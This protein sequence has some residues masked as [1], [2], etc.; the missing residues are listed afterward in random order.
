MLEIKS[1][2]SK[3][4]LIFFVII[5]VFVGCVSVYNPATQK[6]EYYIIDEAAEVNLGKSLAKQITQEQKVWNNLS[7]KARLERIG[8]QIVKVSDRPEINY[9]FELIDQAGINAFALPGGYI[10]VHRG[11]MEACNDDELAFILAHEIGHVAARHS[12]KRLQ[13]S[14]GTNI[15]LSIISAK[16]N[17]DLTLQ[18]LDIVY[19]VVALGYSRKD[20]LLADSL[21]VKYLL[22]SGYNPQAG[23]SL[24]KKLAS[25]NKDDYTLAFLRSHPSIDQRIANIKEKIKNKGGL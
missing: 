23:I 17:S 3:I 1:C 7:Q 12:V 6:T 14:L 24:M 4:S 16:V 19:N 8:K 25:E 9:H 22:R 21:A 18:A 5:S 15:V 2:F 11:A 20:E 13:A 10:Y